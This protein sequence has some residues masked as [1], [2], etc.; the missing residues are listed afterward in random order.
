MRSFLGEEGTLIAAA[1]DDSDGKDG[2][3]VRDDLDDDDDDGE[4]DAKLE[5]LKK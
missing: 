4:I 3:Q 2:D 1:D 5:N